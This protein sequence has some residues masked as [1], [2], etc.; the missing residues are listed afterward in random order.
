[1][2]II[3]VESWDIFCYRWYEEEYG[4]WTYAHYGWAVMAS[5]SFIRNMT[6]CITGIQG[7]IGYC[8][9]L[10]LWYIRLMSPQ[11]F[12]LVW[13][14]QMVTIDSLLL[15]V[16]DY[17]QQIANERTHTSHLIID[18][19]IMCYLTLVFFISFRMSRYREKKRKEDMKNFQ[20][21]MVMLSFPLCVGF[22]LWYAMLYLE[23]TLM[24]L[25]YFMY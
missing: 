1:M 6:W 18:S 20:V 22:I 4:E 11:I 16:T 21:A 25:C 5:N 7:W 24:Y 3:E 23:S 9:L 13:C 2:Y 14:I 19:L 8:I 12:L 15:I 10:P 17:R